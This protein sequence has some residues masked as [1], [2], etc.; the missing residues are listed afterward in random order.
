MAGLDPTG[1]DWSSGEIDLIVA[2]YFSMLAMDLRREP[3]VK[4]HRN[5]ELQRLTGRSRGSIEFKHQNIS[6]VM[7][8][9]GLPWLRGY[10]PLSNFQE[11]LVSGVER[12]LAVNPPTMIAPVPAAQVGVEEGSLLFIE[13]PPVIANDD[14]PSPEPLKR[15]IRKF[16]PASRDEKNR[17]LGRAGE[18]RVL[19]SE[20][21]RLR[22]EGRSDLADRVRWVAD[23]D[24][25]GAGFDIQSFERSG[26]ETFLEVKTTMGD[27]RTPFY[28]SENERLFAEERSDAFRIVRL[29]DFARSMR[30][31]EISPPLESKLI[32]DPSVWKASFGN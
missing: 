7:M 20:I 13:P 18:E 2:D 4:A 15:L 17:A 24:G 10:K 22:N 1:T 3:F 32:L 26:R 29:Y 14:A 31:F 30:A 11:A 12:F 19:A 28:L 9:L 23:L 25:D 5:E 27:A 21:T 8:R 16:D 6:A